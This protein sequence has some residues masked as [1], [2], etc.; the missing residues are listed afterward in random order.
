MAEKKREA[1]SKPVLRR[2][3]EVK[4]E[5]ARRLLTRGVWNTAG[6]LYRIEAVWRMIGRDEEIDRM[7]SMVMHYL[8][9]CAKDLKEERERLDVLLEQNGIEELPDYTQKQTVQVRILSPSISRYVNIILEADAVIQ[10]LDAAW[11]M[12]VVT[13]LERKR[14]MVYWISELRSLRKKIRDLEAKTRGLATGRGRAVSLEQEG[15]EDVI[16][17]VREEK[18]SVAAA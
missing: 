14:R 17:E 6:A 18:E 1:T 12:G 5:L 4:S 10:R 16:E 9:K 2:R 15:Q 11:L 13:N 8:D 3:L 7:E